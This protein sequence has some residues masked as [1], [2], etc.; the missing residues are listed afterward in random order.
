MMNCL[1]TSGTVNT[2][3]RDLVTVRHRIWCIYIGVQLTLPCL[4]L[5]AISNKPE[6]A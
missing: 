2:Q 5:P 3:T 1:L 4:S 6:I